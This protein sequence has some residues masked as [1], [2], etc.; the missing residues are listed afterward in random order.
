MHRSDGETGL[1]DTWRLYVHACHIMV[2]M[3]L[4]SDPIRSDPPQIDL[5]LPDPP[6]SHG[7][8][9]VHAPMFLRSCSVRSASGARRLLDDFAPCWR[10]R[11]PQATLLC[12]LLRSPTIHLPGDDGGH[13]LDD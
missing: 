5:V 3:A 8:S 6:H 9:P 1:C 2:E 13:M 12:A 11:S 10:S 7:A 4:R